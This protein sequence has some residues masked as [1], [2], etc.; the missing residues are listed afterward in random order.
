MDSSPFLI[1]IYVPRW[2]RQNFTA[3]K[4]EESVNKISA[5]NAVV[6]TFSIDLAK[7]KLQVHGFDAKHE[8]CFARALSRTQAAELFRGLGRPVKVVME[9]CSSAHYWGRQLLAL[10][11]EVALI[12]PQF[13][14]PLR[15]GNKTDGNDADAIYE[16]AQRLK[17]RPV[18]VKSIE[19]QDL[20]LTQL[21]R[22]RLVKQ[23]TALTNQLRGILA[24]RGRVFG[25]GL[26]AL[27]EG[28][29]EVLA[30]SPDQEVTTYCLE[31]LQI[32]LADWQRLDERITDCDRRM[33]R[34][35]R[36]H[37]RCQQLMEVDGIGLQTA[38]CFFALVGDGAQ[39]ASGRACG[40]WIGLTPLEASSG[41]RRFLGAITKRGDSTLRW[42][43]VNG[44]RTLAAQAKRKAKHGLPLN[45]RDTWLLGLIQ[46]GGFNK[47]A[48]AMANKNARILWAMLRTGE[49]FRSP[50]MA[51]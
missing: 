8:R 5:I 27:R 34:D 41:E 6:K 17:C 16:A 22:D 38:L 48:V 43:L 7:N 30:R 44:G 14:T 12:P 35:F 4:K 9:A 26:K 49:A 24:E 20:M 46:R 25:K 36:A 21:E 15:I 11:H 42:L 45:E 47:A 29:R 18:P 50:L 23:R 37:P 40:S 39:F 32:Q 33:N 1:G 19:Q 31:W 10:G 28:L 13:V 2:E 51:A 3:T